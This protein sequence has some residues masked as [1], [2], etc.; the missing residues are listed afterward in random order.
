MVGIGHHLPGVCPSPGAL[1][2]CK[3]E[4]LPLEQNQATFIGYSL[5]RE[6]QEGVQSPN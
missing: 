4:K 6:F 5:R 1:K 2:N 3:A